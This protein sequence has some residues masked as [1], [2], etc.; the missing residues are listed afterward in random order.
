MD[1]EI[2]AERDEYVF[3][4]FEIRGRGELEVIEGEGDGE[5][6]G[7]VGRFVYDDEAVFLGR[8]IIEIDMIFRRRE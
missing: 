1:L 2:L 3:A 5:V 4:G 6:E 7:V 8:E